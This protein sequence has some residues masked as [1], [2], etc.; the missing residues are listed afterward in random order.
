M[1]TDNQDVLARA[2]ATLVA[3]RNNTEKI[4]YGIQEKYV[5]EYHAILE[6]LEGIGH[7]L[8]EFRIPREEVGPRVT[9][10]DMSGGRTYTQENYVDKIYFLTKIDALLGY[11]D[12]ISSERPRKIGF[13]APDR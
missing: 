12:L 11:F 1:T 7:T 6:R 13:R 4:N 8:T 9:S 3:L 10:V 5:R 2:Y